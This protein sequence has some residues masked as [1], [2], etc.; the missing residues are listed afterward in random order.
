MVFFIYLCDF[1]CYDSGSPLLNCVYLLLLVLRLWYHSSPLPCC[2]FPAVVPMDPT[3]QLPLLSSADLNNSSSPTL[4]P[5]SD[6]PS[7]DQNSASALH[8]FA[9]FSDAL[10]RG[11]VST[12]TGIAVPPPS[13]VVDPAHPDIN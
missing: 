4:P 3:K 12:G 10:R 6:P 1:P 13:S 7:L 9:S 11:V 5:E 2:A 8:G